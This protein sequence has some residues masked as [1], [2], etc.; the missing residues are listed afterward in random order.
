[1]I[2]TLA[3]TNKNYFEKKTLI[4]RNP[5]AAATGLPAIPFSWA[6]AAPPS[7]GPFHRVIALDPLIPEICLLLHKSTSTLV[8]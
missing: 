8:S 2:A 6:P 5:I 7:S 1:M 4:W 3:T